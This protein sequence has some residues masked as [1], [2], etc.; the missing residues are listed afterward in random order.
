VNLAISVRVG[1]SLVIDPAPDFVRKLQWDLNGAWPFALRRHQPH[2]DIDEP[3]GARLCNCFNGRPLFDRE[4]L[5]FHTPSTGLHD[6]LASEPF[7][8]TALASYCVQPLSNLLG[9]RKDEAGSIQCCGILLRPADPDHL[10][11]A[12]PTPSPSK[13]DHCSFKSLAQ[14]PLCRPAQEIGCL[15]ST[16]VRRGR[17][18]HSP[19]TGPAARCLLPLIA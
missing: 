19:A 16:L 14:A 18:E 4:R 6:E 13:R 10:W 8:T 9:I 1:R 3:T 11:A 12:A 7:G 17:T 15:V 5:D 2:G